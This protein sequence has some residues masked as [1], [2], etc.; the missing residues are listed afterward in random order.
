MMD[1]RLKIGNCVVFK[2]PEEPLKPELPS[3]PPS[4]QKPPICF[5]VPGQ[6]WRRR[7]FV[8]AHIIDSLPQRP[9]LIGSA[10]PW[11]SW[12]R[13]LSR[14]S[15]SWQAHCCTQSQTDSPSPV[16][17]ISIKGWK[18]R[19]TQYL[20]MSASSRAAIRALVVS[21]VADSPTHPPTPLS[22]STKVSKTTTYLWELH[23]LMQE[24]NK[25]LHFSW[26]T[27]SHV[28]CHMT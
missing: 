27:M 25:C 16:W 2:R 1:S 6:A 21:C 8:P 9:K 24:Q 11:S 23:I 13:L 12:W 17:R 5:Q 19:T 14:C 18:E 20:K 28:T 22:T 26:D 15:G 7:R 3:L 4:S 10:S